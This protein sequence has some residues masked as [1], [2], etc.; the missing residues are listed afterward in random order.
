MEQSRC[1]S[2]KNILVKSTKSK[3]SWSNYLSHYTHLFLKL[4]SRNNIVQRSG[5]GF[6]VVNY[7]KKRCHNFNFSSVKNFD[8]G[9]IIEL[10]YL[11][12]SNYRILKLF[13]DEF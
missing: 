7:H 5:V 3:P 12:P 10:K 8:F 9:Q 2:K 6:L 4:K 13:N 11:T 1:F